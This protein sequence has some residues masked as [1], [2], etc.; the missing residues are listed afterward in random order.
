MAV[1]AKQSQQQDQAQASGQQAA[2][3][4]ILS[5]YISYGGLVYI[6]HGISAE[7]NFKTYQPAIE[8]ALSSFAPLTDPARLNV[9]PKKVIVRTVKSPGTLSQVLTS[10]GVPQDKLKE[11]A[12][13]NNLELNS[14]IPSGKLIKTIGE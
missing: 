9:K 7:A 8:S 4:Q 11:L 10:F 6:F 13:L 2:S 5:F 12:L 1:M 14:A 3:N